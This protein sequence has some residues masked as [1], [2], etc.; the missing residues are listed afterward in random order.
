LKSLTLSTEA[1]L[2]AAEA[3][4]KEEIRAAEGAATLDASADDVADNQNCGTTTDAGGAAAEGPVISRA[5]SLETAEVCRPFLPTIIRWCC[6]GAP[7]M[8]LL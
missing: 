2:Q 8:R 5:H 4:H 1:M 7:Q 3:I 6:F